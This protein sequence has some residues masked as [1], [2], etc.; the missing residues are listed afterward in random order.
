MSLSIK[1]V[2]SISSTPKGFSLIEVSIVIVIIGLLLA[3]VVGSKH[4]VQKARINSAQAMTRSSVVNGIPNNK[5]WIESSLAELFLGE[6]LSTGDAITSWVD[7][8]PN[9]TSI[10]ISSVG[11]GPTYSNSINNIQAVQFDANSDSNYLQINNAAF[12]NGTNYTIFIVEKRMA[13]NSIVNNYLLGEAASFSIGYESGT[14][15]IQSHSE[16]SSV[17]NTANIESLSSYSNK[18]RVL[19]FTHSSTDGNEIFINATLANE[20]STSNATTHLSSLTTLAIGKGY[21]GEIGEIVMFDRKLKSVERKE[22]ENYLSDKWNSPNNRDSN[23]SCIA[24]TIL[25]TGCD[26]SCSISI[27]GSSVTSLAASS[28][29][30]FICDGT[31]YNSGTTTATYTCTDGLLDATPAV[32]QCIDDLGC[33][34]GYLSISN[35][36][37]QGCTTTAIVGSSST[38]VAAGSTSVTCDETGYDTITFAAC[39]GG[40]NVTGT[41]GCA[42]GY[43]LN[44]G[45]CEQQCTLTAA[46]I[47]SSLPTDVTDI[48]SGAVEYDCSTYGS[49]TGTVTFDAC[50]NG[51]TLTTVAGS[52][53]EVVACSS[54]GDTVDTTTVP[55]DT[56]HIFTT[57]GATTLV[58]TQAVTAKILVV[59][60]GG[61]GGSNH[62][63][64]AASGG[65]GGGLIY[66]SSVSL[67]AQTYAVVVGNLG[68]GGISSANGSNGGNSEFDSSLV[69]IGG[70]GG[71]GGLKNTGTVGGSGGGFAYYLGSSG[72]S[73]AGT[74]LQGN[75]GG[76]NSRVFWGSASGGGGAGSAGGSGTSGPSTSGSGGA[77]LD[78][79]TEFG[80]AYGV[81]GW[82]AGGGAGA[83]TGGSVSGSG[84]SGGGGATG[85]PGVDGTG[86]G[87]GGPGLNGGTGIVI[88]RYTNP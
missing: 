87:G 41:C 46:S 62:G 11:S 69:A 27:N 72:S 37:A 16:S 2:P 4:L 65:G 29:S 10:S 77:G 67:V 44:G 39:S 50:N 66:S 14:S 42:A 82:F 3:G 5:L 51:A 86:G 74:S 84:G 60:G 7:N 38:I 70:G 43:N 73:I 33:A 36:C 71:L 56:I 23:T 28:S 32:T 24:G 83:A 13:T 88:I 1:K 61:G 40:D 59:A 12:L 35:A 8:S 78:Y 58:C 79:S 6:E 75:A 25:S 18:P 54:D 19:S 20:D 17:D 53:T 31:G 34:T 68:A 85:S 81:S 9:K 80:T 22:V 49:Y 76:S 55:G 63:N 30:T 47:A 57:V 45:V 15:I 64:Y 52:C 21:N 48:D 26:S